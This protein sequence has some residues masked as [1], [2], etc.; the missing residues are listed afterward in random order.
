MSGWQYD[1]RFS[2]IPLAMT[3]KTVTKKILAA[4]DF[5]VPAGAEFSSLEDGRSYPLIRSTN[6]RQTQVNQL[7]TRHLY[8]PRTVV[9]KLIAGFRNCFFRRRCLGGGIHRWNI[10]AAVFR[11]SECGAVLLRVAA[12]VVGDGQHA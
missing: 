7:W 8:L 9:W 11:R 3:N 6:C 4:A 12:N 1:L 10:T 5:P 2:V